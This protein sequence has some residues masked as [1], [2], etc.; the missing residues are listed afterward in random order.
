[1]ASSITALPTAPQRTDAPATFVTNADAWV[2]ALGTFVTEANI[3]AS[4]AETDAAT[5]AAAEALVTP[6][7]TIAIASS[8]FKGAWSSL[9]GALNVPASVGH[10]GLNW[11]LLSNLADVTLK[12]PGVDVEW[13]KAGGGTSVGILMFYGAQQ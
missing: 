1:M 3:V 7:A 12:E 8:N 2:A 9:T 13:Q 6:A 11:I 5:A 10:S 4:E